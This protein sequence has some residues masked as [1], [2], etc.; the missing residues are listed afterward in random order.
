[1]VVAAAMGSIGLVVVAICLS[2]VCG[3]FVWHAGTE[4]LFH[5][6]YL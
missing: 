2:G 1:M 5:K 6:L 3:R 4:K